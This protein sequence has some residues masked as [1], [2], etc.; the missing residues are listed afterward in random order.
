[1]ESPAALMP[2]VDFA[3]DPVEAP[4]AQLREAGHR[5]APVQWG[6]KLA[7]VVLRYD[8]VFAGISDDRAIPAATEYSITAA[9]QG[10]IPLKLEGAAHRDSRGVL[11]RPFR[12]GAIPNITDQLLV[13][14]ADRLIDAFGD[15]RDVDLV[16]DFSRRYTFLVMSALLGIPVEDEDRI[17]ALSHALLPP[18][19]RGNPDE[20]EVE[21]A[22][23][24]ADAAV[25]AMNDYLRP[26]IE[27]RR[28]Q[29]QDDIIS[30]LLASREGGE[31][32]AEA[33]LYDYVRLLFPAG[34]E[35]THLSIAQMMNAV[36]SDT[37]LRD[38]LVEQ[39]EL[40][41]K[42][43]EEATRAASPV[44]LLPRILAQETTICDVTLPADTI[45]LFG[46]LSAN[47]DPAAHDGPEGISL[48]RRRRNALTFGAGPH[49]CLGIHLAKAEMLVSLNRLLDRL[50]GLRLTGRPS[51]P[52]GGPVRWI[53]DL[54]VTFDR[55]C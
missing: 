3:F 32:I 46:I 6:G 38:Q 55:I 44:C 50:P 20:A 30:Y 35:T 11:A 52:E 33:A 51:V 13:P 23:D 47:Q 53:P 45:V 9:S 31:P 7:W 4:L 42:F 37:G 15:R 39:P 40:R 14:L 34:A 27:D 29:P 22:W 36:L 48:T 21:P 54:R 8:D 17:I 1:M 43:V 49:H 16:R 10:R 26:I 24:D 18:L 25:I 19:K 41:P 12:L 2:D 28:R 5:I